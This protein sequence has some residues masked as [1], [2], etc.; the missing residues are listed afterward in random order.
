MPNQATLTIVHYEPKHSGLK[1][2]AKK[3]VEANKGAA[4]SKFVTYVPVDGPKDVAYVWFQHDSHDALHGAGHTSTL[5]KSVGKDK[6]EGLATG[7]APG[8]KDIGSILMHRTA[9]H[10]RK[11][12]KVP[13]YVIAYGLKFDPS[14]GA[15]FKSAARAF[16]TANAKSKNPVRFGV[17][18]PAD[19]RSGI[20]LVLVGVDDL[21]SL[22]H[23]GGLNEPRGHEHF[24][25]A[26]AENVGRSLVDSVTAVHRQI[27]RF[28]PELSSQ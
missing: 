28:V 26:H 19:G 13:P 1:E 7:A 9:S 3:A 2:F 18:R 11:K 27:L 22:D 23:D 16:V 21:K 17:H 20:R 5:S 10:G 15:D 4:G 24:G 12:G 6:A 14:K 8:V 25:Q